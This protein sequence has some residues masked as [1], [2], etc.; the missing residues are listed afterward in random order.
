MGG[1]H[2]LWRFD[3]ERYG[4]SRGSIFRAVAV[5][6]GKL[7]QAEIG[8]GDDAQKPEFEASPARVGE[9]TALGIAG[10]WARRRKLTLLTATLKVLGP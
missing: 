2:P 3:P 8:W 1:G 6:G 5:S 9:G 4:F 7:S 10:A